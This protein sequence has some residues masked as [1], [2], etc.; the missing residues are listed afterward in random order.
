MNIV[1]IN[2]SPRKRGRTG[3]AA[4]FIARAYNADL[5]DLS[6]GSLPLYTGEQE[7]SELQSVKSL[8]QKVKNADAVILA[9]PEYHSGMSGALKNAL[10]FLSSEQFAHKPVALLACAGGGKGGINCLNNLRI[11]ARGVYANVIPKQLVLDPHCFDYDNDG[12]LEEPA[13]LVDDMVQ[14][15]KVYV[16][17]AEI[18]QNETPAK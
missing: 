8:K 14:E 11:V 1:I 12:L 7:Q 15:L 4:R 10:D 9:S 2:G 16:K 5:I 18:V 3:I 13:K 17:A 6:D